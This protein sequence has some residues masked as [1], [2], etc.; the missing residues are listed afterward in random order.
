MSNSLIIT[1]QPSGVFSLQLNGEDV[2]RSEQNRLT[3]VGNYCHFKTANGANVV[4]EQML[5]FSEITLITT[6]TETF[7]SIDQLWQRLIDVGFFGTLGSG[8]GGGGADK[9]TELTDTFPSYLGRDNQALIINESQ[10]RIES[11]PFYN[12]QNFTQLADTPSTLLA[13]KMITTNDSGTALVMSDIPSLP[14]P[15]LASVGTFDYADLATQTTP[16]SFVTNVPKKLTNDGLGATSNS[17]FPPYGV[18]SLWNSIDNSC[19][20]SQLSNGDD[21]GIRIDI[22][23]TTTSANQIVRGYLKLGVGTASE[24]DLQFFSENIKTAGTNNLTFFT[25]VYIGSDEIRNAP[26]DFYLVS[27]GNGSVKINGWYFSV[28]RRSVNIVSVENS[29]T[30]WGSITGSLS[31]Q[32]DLQSSLNSIEDLA[33]SKLNEL[34]EINGYVAQNAPTSLS[35]TSYESFPLMVRGQSNKIFLFYRQGADHATSK[36]VIRMRTSN[37]GGGTW[38]SDGIIASDTIYDCRNVSGGVTP[39]G[40]IV[41]FYMRYNFTASTSFD[42]GFIYSDDDGSTWS[43]YQTIPSG[44]HTFFSPYGEM[45]SIG[46]NKL[47]LC[48]YGETPATPTYSTYIITS[49]DNGLT[50]SSAIAVLTSTSLRYGESSYAYLDG[51]IIVGHVRNSTGSPLYQVIS[52]NNGATWTNQGVTT[53]DTAAQVSPMLATF[54]DPNNQKYIASFYANRGDNKLKVSIAEYATAVAGVS[55]WTRTDIDSHTWTDFGY[56]TVVKSRENNKFLIAYYKAASTTLASIYFKNYTPNYGSIAVTGTISASGNISSSA[57]VSA[58]ADISGKDLKSSNTLQIKGVVTVFPTAGN[59]LEAYNSTATASIIQA[60]NR[61]TSVFNGLNFRGSILQFFIDATEA[62]RIHASRGV[63]IGNATDLGAGTLNVAGNITTI[64]GTTANHAVIK[65]QLDAVA[66]SATSASYTPTLTANGNI[67]SLALQSATW[68]KIGN[69]VTCQI[70]ATG[71]LTASPAN[72]SYIATLP[73]TRL[74]ALKTV[75]VSSLIDNSSTPTG[76]GIGITQANATQ[77]IFNVNYGGS[78]TGTGRTFIMN[79]TYDVTQ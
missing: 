38:S 63:S 67:T 35:S 34:Y 14:E 43:N 76:S 15:S 60:Y 72:T 23:V 37:D 12:V 20:F 71:S 51:G 48:W 44:T 66:S 17:A 9:F 40:R 74:A 70:I 21:T 46:N 39:T 11:V 61:T 41:L 78:T 36:G 30:T 29:G 53:V 6:I 7:T 56:P 22:T 19:G 59:G 65:S 32:T 50:W 52:T 45:I 68:T 26:A 73:F 25:K 33:K 77:A 47:M 13:N 69:I 58:V 49:S 18:T 24:Y 42:Q 16:L 31:S 27:D 55:G 3:M 2:V 4:K 28:T 75:G 54:I 79:F 64:A 10:Q 1:K 57:N 62:M 5:L 8:G